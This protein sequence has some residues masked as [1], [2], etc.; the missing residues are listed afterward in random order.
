MGMGFEVDIRS[1][2]EGQRDDHKTGTL[3]CGTSDDI[4]LV[5]TIVPIVSSPSKRGAWKKTVGICNCRI[6]HWNHGIQDNFT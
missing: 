4:S 5:M 6:C 2:S 1:R 3:L